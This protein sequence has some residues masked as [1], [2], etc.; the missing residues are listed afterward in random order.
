[1]PPPLDDD[2]YCSDL[3]PPF[4]VLDQ[5]TSLLHATAAPPQLLVAPMSMSPSPAKSYPSPAAMSSEFYDG[6]EA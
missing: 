2:Q 1:M 3:L 6:N 4:S 5:A